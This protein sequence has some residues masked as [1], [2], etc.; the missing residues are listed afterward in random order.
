MSSFQSWSTWY[1]SVEW[2]LKF[3][4]GF[5]RTIGIIGLTRLYRLPKEYVL[6]IGLSLIFVLPGLLQCPYS[7]YIYLVT[8]FCFWIR[9]MWRVQRYNNDFESFF[10]EVSMTCLNGFNLWLQTSLHEK[11]HGWVWKSQ[12]WALLSHRR[13]HMNFWL[14]INFSFIHVDS[15]NIW[16]RFPSCSI[17][18]PCYAKKCTDSSLSSWCFVEYF[19]VQNESEV[20][21]ILW[22]RLWVA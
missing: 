7:V 10:E 13:E 19:N 22:M 14:A 18:L 20:I 21:F 1:M 17:S 5:G 16:N 3:L 15:N 6:S 9:I 8:I 2:V 4:K 12:D 11:A